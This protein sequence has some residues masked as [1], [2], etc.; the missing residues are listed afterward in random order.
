[1]ARKRYST[2]E[3]IRKL[4]EADVLI[5]RGQN[6]SDVIRHLGVSDVTYYRW[7]K[8]YGGLKIDQAKRSKDLEKENARLKRLRP[9]GAEFFPIAFQCSST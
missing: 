9:P 2:E 4:P 1:M 5:G 6:V 7:R 3:I 8:E